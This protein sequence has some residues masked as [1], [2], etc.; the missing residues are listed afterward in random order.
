V[1]SASFG[2]ILQ[3]LPTLYLLRRTIGGLIQRFPRAI[4][5]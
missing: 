3:L 4:H 1:S 5:L 2:T